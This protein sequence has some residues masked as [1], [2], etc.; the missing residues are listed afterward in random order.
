MIANNQDR[1]STGFVRAMARE[2]LVRHA[3]SMSVDQALSLASELLRKSSFLSNPKQPAH[4]HEADHVELA[5]S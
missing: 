1:S 2:L 3:G 4:T 5:N